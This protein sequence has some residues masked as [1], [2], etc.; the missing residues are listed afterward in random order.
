MEN[1][2]IGFSK[3]NK[4]TSISDWFIN[5]HKN[6][7]YNCMY[8]KFYSESLNRT[9]VY[10]AVDK[11]VRFVGNKVWE[12]YANEISSYTISIKKC[13]QIRLLQFCADNAGINCTYRERLGFFIMS[14][15][16]LNKKTTSINFNFLEKIGNILKLEG[17]E[18]KKDVNFL[19]FFDIDKILKSNNK[20]NFDPS[21]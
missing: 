6:A 15:F 4:F 20:N 11:G 1:I 9:L 8:V 5:L 10:E 18:F 21:I 3:R 7:P 16:K 17:Y 12:D 2:T 19:N 13:N 14:V